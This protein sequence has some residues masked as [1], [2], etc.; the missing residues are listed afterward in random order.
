[1]KTVKT[2]ARQFSFGLMMAVTL[3]SAVVSCDSILDEDD[4]DCSVEYRVKFK[5]D[6]NMKYADAFSREVSSVALYAFDDNGKLVYQKTEA[7]DVLAA[8]GYSMA[9]DMEPGDYHLITWAGLSDEASFSVP[10]ITQG[11]SSLEELQCKM[12]RIYSRAADGSAVVSSKLSS[13]WHGEVTKQS[14]TRAATQQVVTVPLVK[15]TNTIRVILQQM[16]GVTVD[17]D[18]FEFTITDD[19]GLMNYD[20]KLISDETVG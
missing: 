20:N 16:D 18:K 19:N 10:L 8:D 11:V 12:D 9:V 6:Y 17:V 3:G 5:Y 13:L 15:N 2:F 1:M 4:V 14:F 7:G